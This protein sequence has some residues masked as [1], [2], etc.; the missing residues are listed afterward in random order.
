MRYEVLTTI[1][2]PF[3]EIAAIENVIRKNGLFWKD[4]AVGLYSLPQKIR[5]KITKTLDGQLAR[6]N[7]SLKSGKF[8]GLGTIKEVITC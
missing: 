1:Y 2:A 8:S 3:G 4:D 6:F 7:E 5:E